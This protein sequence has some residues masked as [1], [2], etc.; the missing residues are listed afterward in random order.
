MLDSLA[1]ISCGKSDLRFRP[2]ICLSAGFGHPMQGC[3]QDS[4]YR[5]CA[6]FYETTINETFAYSMEQVKNNNIACR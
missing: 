3:L 4:I 2:V 5:F 1:S 6:K